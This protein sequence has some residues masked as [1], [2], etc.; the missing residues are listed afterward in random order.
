MRAALGNEGSLNL[1]AAFNAGLAGSAVNTMGKLE[2][3]FPAFGVDI[4][5]YRRSATF[6][7]LGEDLAHGIGDSFDAR[8]AQAAGDLLRMNAGAEQ[9]LICVNVTDAANHS[10]IEKNGFNGSLARFDSLSEVGE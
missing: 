5:R 6:D 3:A 2:A 4:V 8:F 10:L 1:S 9:C 7:C